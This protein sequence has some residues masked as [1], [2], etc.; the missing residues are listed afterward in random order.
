MCSCSGRR[1][2]VVWRWSLTSWSAR[3]CS[4]RASRR[5]WCCSSARSSVLCRCCHTCSAPQAEAEQHTDDWHCPATGVA[6]A[7]E[8]LRAPRGLTAAGH[9]RPPPALTGVLTLTITDSVSA[10]LGAAL[11]HCV[12]EPSVARRRS[13]RRLRHGDSPERRDG[14]T[15]GGRRAA[16][17][18]PAAGHDVTA[19]VRSGHPVSSWRRPV[20]RRGQPF[21]NDTAALALW[22]LADPAVVTR[23]EGDRN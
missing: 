15:G 18:D 8:P 9:H 22:P 14:A 19:V 16:R 2:A 5:C 4:S 6:G 21:D 20:T 11:R 7:P 23:S 17:E 3:W 1:A 10:V 13:P 12:G